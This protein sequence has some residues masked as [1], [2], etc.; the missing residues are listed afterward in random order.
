[1]RRHGHGGTT[2][3]PLAR[4]GSGWGRRTRPA[5]SAVIRAIGKLAARTPVDPSDVFLAMD[6]REE[7]SLSGTRPIV[8]VSQMRAR[9]D[10]PGDH[11]LFP[12]IDTD[13]ETDGLS[14]N[15]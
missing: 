11:C 15:G 8:V 5:P 14:Q 10:G 2:R 9:S 3:P 12:T 7:I 6:D 4:P 13:R 1:M